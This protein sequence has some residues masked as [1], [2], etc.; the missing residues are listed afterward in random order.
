MQVDITL[1]LTAYHHKSQ[2]AKRLYCAVT[3]EN[4]LKHYLYYLLSIQIVRVK[5]RLFANIKVQQ[6]STRIDF[7][8]TETISADWLE[9]KLKINPRQVSVFIASRIFNLNNI[10]TDFG[11]Y[12]TVD[13]FKNRFSLI[14]LKHLIQLR[15]NSIL[16]YQSKGC[17]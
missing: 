7:F 17:K 16:I 6:Q 10:P 4:S 2:L 8:N 3:G 9:L 13:N 5:E 11:F 15:S 14:K 12:V 1:A